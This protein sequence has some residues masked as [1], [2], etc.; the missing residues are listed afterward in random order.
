MSFPRYKVNTHDSRAT[1]EKVNKTD[2][3]QHAVIKR[4]KME[5]KKMLYIQ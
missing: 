3:I 5:K 1:N 2:K 4:M